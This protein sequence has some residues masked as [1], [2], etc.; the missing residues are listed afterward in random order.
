MQPIHMAFTMT[1]HDIELK[2]Y[3]DIMFRISQIEALLYEV[4][5]GK[6]DN[7]DDNMTLSL[8]YI[9]D[10]KDKFRR[11]ANQEDS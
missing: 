4:L 5:D 6:C 1:P 3:N 2:R 9:K 11:Y 8:V 7:V 10:I